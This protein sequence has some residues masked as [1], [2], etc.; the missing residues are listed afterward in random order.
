MQQNELNAV[1]DRQADGYDTQWER[2]API[3]DGVFFA[4]QTIFSALP[5]DA[6]ILCV[7]V[8]TGV[9]LAFLAR[10]FPGWQFTAVEPSG[11]MLEACRRRADTQGFAARCRFHQ[12]YLDS[13]TTEQLHDGAT[14][15]LV[16][17]FILERRARV[18]FFAA[19]AAQLAPGALLAS[20]DL[21][22]DTVSDA[23]KALLPLWLTMMSPVPIEPDRL[24]RTRAAY[25]KDVAILPPDAVAA[26]MQSGGFETPVQFFQAGLLHAWFTR[27]V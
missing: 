24:E 20:S 9:E 26:I 11:A 23:Y 6:R 27:R 3:R 14:C 22:S 18:E 15:F 8:G 12:G 7:G 10:T 5:P 25:A 2:M 21:A 13:L 17:Q 19:I 16:S 4:L 1:F